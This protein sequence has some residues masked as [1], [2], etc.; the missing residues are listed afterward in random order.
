MKRAGFRSPRT[1]LQDPR[2]EPEIKGKKRVCAVCGKRFSPFQK[3]FMITNGTKAFSV[4]KKC[5]EK[6]MEKKLLKEK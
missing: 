2:H 6:M 4:H 1:Y 5:K 3:E